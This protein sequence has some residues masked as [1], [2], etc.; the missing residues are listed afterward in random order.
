[1][2]VISFLTLSIA[3]ALF[4]IG[5]AAPLEIAALAPPPPSVRQANGWTIVETQNFRVWTK[6]TSK[7]TQRWHDM[8]ACRD[9][10]ARQWLGKS[11]SSPWEPKCDVVLHTVPR[12]YT[13]AVP[14]GEQTRGSS[15]VDLD[16]EVVV[17][18]RIDL[19]ADFSDWQT[20][21][22]PHELTHILLTER[23]GPDLPPRWA[24]EGMALL[25]DLPAKQELHERDRRQADR[26]GQ[27]YSAAEL[28]AQADYPTARR[29]PAYYGASLSLTRF[30][31]QRKS[32]KTFVEFLD[33]VNTTGPDRALRETYGIEGV[34]ELDRQWRGASEP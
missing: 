34:G 20:A 4:A 14:G 30:L 7:D 21:T 27:A 16:G 12:S 2:D 25:A 18:R 3:A 10:L 15:V 8:E 26:Q 31:V 28:L 13:Q 24:D 32:A 19:R 17:T 22:F 1:M 5:P 6:G 29:M 23:F 9:R 33:R 11:M